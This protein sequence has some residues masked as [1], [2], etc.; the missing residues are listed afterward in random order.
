MVNEPWA[1]L[2]IRVTPKISDSP[3]ATRN[4]TDPAARPPNA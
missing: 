3:E 1:K 2:T 4:S